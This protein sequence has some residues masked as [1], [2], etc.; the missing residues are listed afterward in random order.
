MVM[1]IDLSEPIN[2]TIDVATSIAEKKK[3]VKG[4]LGEK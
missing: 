2:I 3:G 4:F 1:L